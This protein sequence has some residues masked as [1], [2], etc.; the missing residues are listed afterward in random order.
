[1]ADSGFLYSIETAKKLHYINI[2]G[3]FLH[4]FSHCLF[5]RLEPIAAIIGQDA[6]FTLGRSEI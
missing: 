1:M 6:A 2:L 4:N 3:T 5:L